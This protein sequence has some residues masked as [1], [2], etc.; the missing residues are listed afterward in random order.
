MRELYG[1][2]GRSRTRQRPR[3]LWRA[4][5]RQLSSRTLPVGHIFQE[6]PD[7]GEF[8]CGRCG[9]K[10]HRASRS[11]EGAKIRRLHVCETLAINRSSAVLAHEEDEP[12]GSTD[13]GPDGML[14]PSQIMTQVRCPVGRKLTSRVVA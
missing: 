13:I 1:I 9:R 2:L 12:M 4:R 8:S 3:P 6:S 7:T 11:K 10:T 5:P 14:R